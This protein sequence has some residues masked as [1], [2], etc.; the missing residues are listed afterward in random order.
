VKMSFIGIDVAKQTLVCWVGGRCIQIK[1]TA[2]AISAFL[3]SLGPECVIGV[4]ITSKYHL[5]V[6][7]QAYAMGFRVYALNPVDCARYRQALHGRGKTDKIDAELIARFLEREHDTL[8]PYVPLP[9]EISKLRDA[10]GRRD[11]VV[12]SRASL[13]LSFGDDAEMKKLSRKAFKELDALIERLDRMIASLL[14]PLSGAAQVRAIP[15]VG[16][17]TSAESLSALSV[18]EFKSAD[19]FVAYAGLDCRPKDSGPRIGKRVLS[20]RGNRRLRKL[21][22]LCALSGPR[23]ECWKAYYERQ[24]AKGL[25]KIQAVVALARKIA[26]TIWSIYT[27]RTEFNPSRVSMQKA[28]IPT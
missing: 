16:A 24:L 27:Y 13:Q 19:S 4:E 10:L 21:L 8:R 18:G 14:A 5:L 25:K 11:A 9:A 15:C 28:S 23:T 20:K 1:N 2:A 22:F 6:L 7:E 3:K 26:R 17:L 12:R